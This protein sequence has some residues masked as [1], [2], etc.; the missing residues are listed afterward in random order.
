[1]YCVLA[2]SLAKRAPGYTSLGF[3]NP[4][5]TGSLLCARY[6]RLS[7]VSLVQD[8]MVGLY[9]PAG[10]CCLSGARALPP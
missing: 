7:D 9:Q 4:R 3:P 6:A 2:S 8:G 10:S 5:M 1:V